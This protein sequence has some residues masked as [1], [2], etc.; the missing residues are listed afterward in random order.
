[1]DISTIFLLRYGKMMQVTVLFDT[2]ALDAIFLLRY[3][4]M[5]QVTVLFDTSAL[6]D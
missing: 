1:V 5:M 6:D 2:S 3:G 4:K